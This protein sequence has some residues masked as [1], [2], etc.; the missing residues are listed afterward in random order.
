MNVRLLIIP[1]LITTGLFAQGFGGPYGRR[2]GTSNASSTHTPPTPAQLAAAELTRIAR[3]LKLDSADTS[4]LTGNAT[5][6]GYI[7]A[8]E[9]TLQ[10]NATTLKTAYTALATDVATGNT[11]D[12]TTQEGKIQTAVNG[13][14]QARVTAASQVV[15]A[16]PG[17]GLSVTLTSAQLTSVAQLLIGG[18]GFGRRF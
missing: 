17:A 1:A 10:G 7:E 5:L 6:A 4:K 14:F 12:A 2:A 11:N 8:E 16:L 9:T 3:F 13:D 18:G 15:A